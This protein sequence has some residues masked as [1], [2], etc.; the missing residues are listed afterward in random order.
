[1]LHFAGK[2]I[3]G[4]NSE[5]WTR[6]PTSPEPQTAVPVSAAPVWVLHAGLA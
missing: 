3:F 4:D 5:Q 1:M 2:L 6:I